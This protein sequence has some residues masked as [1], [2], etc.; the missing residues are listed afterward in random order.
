M[1]YCGCGV[2]LGWLLCWWSN[3]DGGMVVVIMVECLSRLLMH[4]GGR[5][6]YRSTGFFVLLQV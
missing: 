3:C 2:V 5:L 1:L 4:C 6:L